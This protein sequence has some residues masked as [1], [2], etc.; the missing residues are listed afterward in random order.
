MEFEDACLL[1]VHLLLLILMILWRAGGYVCSLVLAV[2]GYGGGRAGYGS[3]MVG[4]ISV[5]VGVCV[6]VECGERRPIA[7]SRGAPAMYG[8]E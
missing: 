7:G 2:T 5:V 8:E 4:G 1:L 6:V 3:V